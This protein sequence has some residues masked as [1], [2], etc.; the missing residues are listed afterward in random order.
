[1]P[2]TISLLVTAVGLA[3]LAVPASAAG[4]ACDGNACG[5]VSVSFDGSQWTATNHSNRRVKVAFDALW[6][7]TTFT[8]NLAPGQ[9]D[10]PGLTGHPLVTFRNP[11]HAN[12]T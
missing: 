11:Y 9:S 8:L 3:I 12:Y 4:P 1:M 2:K 5:A 7:G 10:V 6:A